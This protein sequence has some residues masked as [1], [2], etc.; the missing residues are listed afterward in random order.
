MDLAAEG[1]DELVRDA[2]VPRPQVQHHRVLGHLQRM[3][4]RVWGFE[5]LMG[6][7]TASPRVA[8]NLAPASERQR[9]CLPPTRHDTMNAAKATR[10]DVRE[11]ARRNRREAPW[12][13]PLRTCC[14]HVAMPCRRHTRSLSV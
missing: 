8:R 1:G 11:N 3:G 4:V 14:I 7:L 13:L 10:E 2:A 9:A 12:P 5:V 6:V